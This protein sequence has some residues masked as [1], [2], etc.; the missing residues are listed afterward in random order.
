MENRLET[1]IKYLQD[2]IDKAELNLSSAPKLKILQDYAATQGYEI[3][4]SMLNMIKIAVIYARVSSDK[5]DVD[6]SISAQ[7]KALRDYANRNGYLVVLEF[8]DEAETGK[9]TARKAFREMIS[10]ARHPQKPFDVI[11]VWKY[12]RFARN[13]EDSIV[14]KTMLRK[15]GIQVISI[16]EP[17]EDT[18]TG[19][20]MEAIIESLDEF[21][22]DNLGEEVTRGLRE[23]ASRGFYLSARPPYGYRKIRVKDGE[24]ERTKLEIDPDQ[25]GIVES[26]F[27]DILR[28]KG[29]MQITKELNQKGIASPKNRKWGKT[30]L[31]VIIANEAYTG[32]LVWG[33]NSK[34]GLEP[35]RIEN[36][37]PVIV[38]RS[39]FD[40][41]QQLLSDRTFKSI[42]PQR[43]FSNYLLSGITYCGLCG[44]AYTGA[45]AKSGQFSYYICGTLNRQG[46]GSCKARYLSQQKFEALMI[47]K[48]RDGILVEENLRHIVELVNED[49]DTNSLEYR[50][51]LNTILEDLTNANQRLDHLYDAVETGQ[52]PLADLAP[53]IHDLK[54]RVDKLMARK[55]QLDGLLSDRRVELASP[56]IVTRFASELRKMLELSEFTEKKAFLRSFIE[57][58]IVTKD[59]GIIR[60]KFPLNGLIEEKIS[61]LPIVH[62]GGRCWARTSEVCSPGFP[63]L[64]IEIIT[65]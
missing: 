33:H 53:R 55:L 51:E 45:E 56:E 35:I 52:I 48:V 57:K 22:S 1:I 44:K 16:N 58:I 13:R 30:S 7:I 4:E 6:L 2:S 12:S 3:T 38:E 29:L 8:V 47:Q 14:Y 37:C 24:K 60:Y 41:V 46:S 63:L 5:Q 54:G 59:D 28:G 11:L 39:V 31:R 34:R 17:T 40:K 32:T 15:H 18:P 21:Y 61:V 42:H 23:S 25:A 26:I 10:L 64:H 9:N 49:T 36:A 27:Q 19:R 20:L 65:H 62:Y 43:A 50:A